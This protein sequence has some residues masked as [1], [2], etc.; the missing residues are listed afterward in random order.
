M[1]LTVVV[2]VRIVEARVKVPLL[3]VWTLSPP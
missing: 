3:P 1:Q 2:E